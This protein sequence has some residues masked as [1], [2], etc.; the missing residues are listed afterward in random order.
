LPSNQ[1]DKAMESGDSKIHEVKTKELY[2]SG[3]YLE[4]NPTWHAEDS[5]WKAQHIMHIIRRN[6]LSPNSICE[7]GCG[8]GEILN[9]LHMHLPDTI[10]FSGYEISPQAFDLCQQRQKERLR[11]FLK[12]LLEDNNAFFDVVLA[13]DVIEHVEDY[14]S[15]LRKLRTKGVYKIFHIPLDI[16]VQSILRKNRIIEARR[17]VGHIHYFTKETALATLVDTGYEILDF[18]YTPSL[19]DLRIKSNKSLLARLPRKIMF[20]LNQDLASKVLG[21]FDLMILSK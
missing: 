2:A 9:Q 12:E 13:I 5:P 6:G 18:F 11:F 14:F 8:A 21:G 3:K 15:F 19:I 1:G 20:A 16:S 17:K 10:V 7:V 4:K